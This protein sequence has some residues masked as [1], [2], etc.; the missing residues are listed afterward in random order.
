MASY[1]V[2]L[3]Y[4]GPKK[5]T[6]IVDLVFEENQ[7]GK[8]GLPLPTKLVGK[9][10][11]FLNRTLSFSKTSV[12]ISLKFPEKSPYYGIVVTPSMK[13]TDIA[14]TQGGIASLTKL[15]IRIWA[16][17]GMFDDAFEAAQVGGVNEFQDTLMS[18]IGAEE[19]VGAETDVK[20]YA[21]DGMQK[22]L[23]DA[24]KP[25]LA[26]ADQ[27]VDRLRGKLGLPSVQESKQLAI[28]MR[29]Q[30]AEANEPAAQQ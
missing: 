7:L 16:N 28:A 9:L 2:Q 12:E 17:E 21:V 18:A 14:S 29:K 13:V 5:S 11:S 10:A 25:A 22:A 20:L 19:M 3:S 8:N 1:T 4:A 24:K 6:V 23:R 15:F 26:A 27:F 30:L